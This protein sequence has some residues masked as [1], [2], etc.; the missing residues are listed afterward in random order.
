MSELEINELLNYFNKAIEKYKL[1]NNEIKPA[2]LLRS[3]RFSTICNH[4]NH[5]KE[6]KK[7]FLEVYS[8]RDTKI[9]I[10]TNDNFQSFWT[11]NHEL[12]GYFATP[13]NF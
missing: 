13:I 6:R 10:Y 3:I 4:I 2:K 8:I 5:M 7:T 1:D 11:I 9:Y 12:D